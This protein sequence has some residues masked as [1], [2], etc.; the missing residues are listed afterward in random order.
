MQSSPRDPEKPCMPVGPMSIN[1]SIDKS[2]PLYLLYHQ[3][4]CFIALARST[5]SSVKML[6][7]RPVDKF[8]ACK[9]R[10]ATQPSLGFTHLELRKCGAIPGQ[11]SLQVI[12]TPSRPSGFS[13]RLWYFVAQ[14]L[15]RCQ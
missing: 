6:F 7:D 12:T 14:R 13:I 11:L 4:H 8:L 2:K 10:S 1:Q 3:S 15:Q 5:F 9:V